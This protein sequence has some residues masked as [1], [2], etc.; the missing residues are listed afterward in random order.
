MTLGIMQPYFF[1]YIG[2]WQLINLVDTFVIY[3]DVNFIKQGYINKNSILA[4]SKAQT[5][6]LELIGASSNKHINEID[7]GRNIKKML[8]TI[9]QNYIKAPYFNTIYPVLEEILNY[10]EKNLGRYLGHSL[11]EIA[12]YLQIDTHFIYSSNIE[13][14]NDL[15]AED[16]V[17]EICNILDADRYINAIGGQE[18]YSKTN[19]D[20]RDIEL[21]FLKPEIKEYQQLKDGFIPHLSIID[22]MMFNSKDEIKIMLEKHELI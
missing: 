19:F 14:D 10:E 9:K 7:V 5:I 6:T 18:L 13:K 20:N 3:D 12:K 1:P 15:K 4:H 16:K 22:V 2:Y 17:L 11:I 8:K 21:S